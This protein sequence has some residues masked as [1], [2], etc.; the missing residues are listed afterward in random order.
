MK[1]N[2]RTLSEQLFAND[3]RIKV[4]VV[5]VVLK[6]SKSTEIINFMDGD[7]ALVNNYVNESWVY[8]F[9]LFFPFAQSMLSYSI[10][11]TRPLY[12]L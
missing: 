9:G 3:D 4:N 11:K 10:T 8:T 6:K 7:M 12:N 5:V 2:T 1:G